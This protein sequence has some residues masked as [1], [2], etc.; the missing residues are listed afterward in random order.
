MAHYRRPERCRHRRDNL[1]ARLLAIDALLLLAELRKSRARRALVPGTVGN[2][3]A[4]GRSPHAWAVN[5]AFGIR[6]C[7]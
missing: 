2:N 4:R 1:P 6:C 3:D 7:S 5:L